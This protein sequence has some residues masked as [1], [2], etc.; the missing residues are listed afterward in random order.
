M[1]WARDYYVGDFGSE[2]L[3]MVAMS[4][5]KSSGF[6]NL[7]LS[8][9]AEKLWPSFASC[10]IPAI[11]AHDAGISLGTDAQA[12]RSSLSWL[13]LTGD[14]ARNSSG[15]S[16]TLGIQVRLPS[17]CEYLGHDEDVIQFG[18]NQVGHGLV[19]CGTWITDLCHAGLGSRTCVM[20][21]LTEVPGD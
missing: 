21:D 12:G 7:Y 18:H 17:L 6:D 4:L 5:P 10:T 3:I 11:G 9:H 1:T 20:R 15:S 13:V 8:G 14:G 2:R 19:S 16:V